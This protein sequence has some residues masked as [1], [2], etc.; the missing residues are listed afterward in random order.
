V[1]TADLTPIG[2]AGNV[3]MREMLMQAY[4]P[5]CVGCWAKTHRVVIELAVCS[6]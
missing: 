4:V 6:C 5:G 2:G 3:G 1:S